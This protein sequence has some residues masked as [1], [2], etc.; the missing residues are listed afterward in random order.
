MLL[1]TTLTVIVQ[2]PDVP[3]V[4]PVSVTLVSPAFAVT[5]PSTAP[6]PVQTIVAPGVGATTMPAGR[7]SVNVVSGIV[8]PAFG[9]VST[10]DSVMGSPTSPGDGEKVFEPV[11]LVND[12]TESVA[13]AGV[14]LVTTVDTSVAWKP[15]TA[16][17]GV[18]PLDGPLA[19]MVFCQFPG[20]VDT[21]SSSK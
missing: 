9:L 1:T 6:A 3:I 7:L 10:M 13:T 17:P 15:A 11:G 16:P 12:L 2:A 5:A 18:N 20:L 21:T 14:V 8:E 19:G 4:P